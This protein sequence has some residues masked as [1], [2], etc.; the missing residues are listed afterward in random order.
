MNKKSIIILSYIFL[1]F[2]INLF[3]DEPNKQLKIGLLAPFSGE[4]KNLGNSLLLS[5]QLALRE[6]D[7]ERIKII[8]RDTGSNN[9]E[10]F[11]NAIQEIID[12]GANIIVGPVDD[13]YF[14]ELKKYKDTIFISLSNKHPK[15]KNN[16]IS[17]GISL[18]SQILAIENFIKKKNKKKTVIMFP[19]NKYTKFIDE[20]I[21]TIKLKDYK[22]FKYNSDP[23]ILTGEIE[24]LTN[25]S[26]RKRNLEFR[27]K[28]LENKEDLRSKNE[29]EELE[30]KYTLGKVN[31]DS[32]III[33]FGN[34]LKSVL[35]SLAFA[36]VDD[37]EVLFT[38]VNQWFDDSIFYE[39]SVKNLYYPS[40]NLKEF[41]KYNKKFFE[42]FKLHPSEISILSY[43]AV[44]LIYYIWKEKKAINSIN[45]FFIKEKIKGKIGTFNFNKGVVSQELKIYKTHNDKFIER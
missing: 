27:K 7:D 19:N 24:K 36:D 32:I 28:L 21:K 15:I 12:S 20:N 43:D 35:A 31:F 2:N 45:D 33:D 40:V 39:N 11:N 34:N 8:P 4:F 18:E 29:L 42:T 17:I 5:T 3:A 13:K 30:Q 38:S 22:V 23:K 6:I 9:K 14:S 25:Y 16:I 37:R 44:G 1:F 10:Q 26:Q 41:K